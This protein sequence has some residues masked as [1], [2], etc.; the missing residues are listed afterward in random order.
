MLTEAEIEQERALHVIAHGREP[1]L[2][3]Y[4]WDEALK[5]ANGKTTSC[6]LGCSIPIDGFVR[7]DIA[8]VVRADE[9]ENDG[10]HWIAVMRL[11]DGRWAF[12]SA[13]CDFTGWDCQASGHV[14]VADTLKRLVQYGLGADERVRLGL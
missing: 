12:L 11:R 6:V 4:D 7:A 2:E 8:Y 14:L 13:G 9:G 1:S 3:G 10:P 5:Y